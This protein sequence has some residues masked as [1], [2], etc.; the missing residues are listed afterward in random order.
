MEI[1]ILGPGCPRCE[2]VRNR[3]VDVLAE[4]NIAADVQKVTDMKKI[5]EY[6]I[7]ATP[8]L[9]INGKVKSWGRLPSKDEIRKWIEEE[10]KQ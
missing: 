8:G 4:L 9:V 6:K 5:M 2:E 10:N 3:T 7:M 1:R